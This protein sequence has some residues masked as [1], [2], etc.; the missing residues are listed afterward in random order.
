MYHGNDS[1]YH[2]EP[3]CGSGVAVIGATFSRNESLA[4]FSLCLSMC[5]DFVMIV[6]NVKW[7]VC[8]ALSC[9]KAS[10]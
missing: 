5:P 3:L 1:V 2:V 9:T 7:P 4:H 6:G 10:C 8:P